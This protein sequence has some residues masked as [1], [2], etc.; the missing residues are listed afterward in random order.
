MRRHAATTRRH[1]TPPAVPL[2]FRPASTTPFQPL[3]FPMAVRQ[4]L[5]ALLLA[6]LASAWAPAAAQR[7]VPAPSASGTASVRVDTTISCR[8][9]DDCP[10]LTLGAFLTRVLRTSPQARLS[11]LAEDRAAAAL[12]G[13]RG[14][15]DPR[16]VS[17]YEYKTK[18]GTDKLNVLRS[19]LR[20]PL[21]LPLSPVLKADYRRGLGAS[22]DPSV[23][24]SRAGETSVG[25]SLSPLEGLFAGKRRTKLDKARLAPRR[26]RAR[27]AEKRNKLLRDA[28]HAFWAWAGARQKLRIARD[29]LGLA[30]RRRALVTRRARAGEVPA[31]DSVEAAQITAS[32]RGGVARARR[33]ATQKRIALASFLGPRPGRAPADTFG[34]APPPLPTDSLP[35]APAAPRLSPADAGFSDAAG[36]LPVEG[37]VDTA[38]AR[39]PVLRALSLK[40]RQARIEQDLARGRRW[41]N[42]KLEAKAV[43]YGEGPLNMTDVKVGVQ[44]EQPLFFRNERSRAEKARIEARRVRLKRDLARRTVRADVESALA[45]LRASRRRL[46]AARRSVRLARRLRRA[47]QRR[48]DEGQGTLFRLNQREEALAKARKRRVEA[49]VDRLRARATYRWATGMIGEGRGRL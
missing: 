16:L 34:Y 7:P 35:G 13:A 20:Q 4:S 12:L 15:F 33:A 29:L 48:F 21:N 45:A 49:R 22:V 19:G 31:M 18:D 8:A 25:V 14:Q 5:P 9:G 6:V 3:A 41:P 1:D 23:A 17:G 32:R 2:Q 36:R 26:A 11:R 46:R 37:A 24:T 27:Q 28:T 43:S 44:V 38:L 39:R 40:R 10:T 47:E 42:L 30:Q